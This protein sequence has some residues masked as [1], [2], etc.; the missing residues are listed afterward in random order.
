[1]SPYNDGLV[2]IYNDVA[3]IKHIKIEGFM[4]IDNKLQQLRQH[5]KQ[6][7]IAAYI[8]PSADFHQ[9]EMVGDYFQSRAYVS[10]FTGSQGTAVITKD[11]AC[12]WTD[13]RYFVQAELEL[14]DS[15][16]ELMKMR[17]P[18]YPTIHEFLINELTCGD[19]IGFDGRTVDM[20][21]GLAIQK[22]AHDKGGRV[23]TDID[24]IGLIWSDRPALSD[25]KVW[26][27]EEAYAGESSTSKLQRVRENMKESD[28][29][30]HL[31]T[32]LDDIAWLLNIRGADV[33]YNPFVLSYVCVWQDR[34]D[35]YID[36]S[37]LGEEVQAYLMNLGVK[38]Y[39]Y[40]SIYQRLQEIEDTNILLDESRVN[41]RIYSMIQDTDRIIRHMNPTILMK[42]KKNETEMKNTRLAHQ[43][44]GVA[45]TK[46]MYW[47]K[48][49]KDLGSVTERSAAAYME[50]LRS[51]QEGFLEQSFAPIVG[52]N[53][54]GAI[55]H[56][57]STK[58]TDVPLN[59]SGF[60]LVDTG[61]QYYEGTT[62][63][64]R[65]FAL[66]TITEEMKSHFTL[67]ATSMLSL[68]DAVFLSGCTGNN[69]DYRAREKFWKRGLD[70]KHGTGHGVGHL[71][72]VHEP[73]I[74]I[75]WQN[76]STYPAFEVGMVVSN[77]PG[78]YIEGK[79][80]I[81]LENLL[82]VQPAFET[83][84]GEFLKFETLTLA[85]IDLDAIAVDELSAEEK[86]LLNSYHK[87]VYDELAPYMDDKEL[88]W[89][90]EYTRVV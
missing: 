74:R 50:Q 56:Y 47:I 61:G 35:L 14:S 29:D 88:E 76:T 43:K 8:V 42:S 31:I 59:Q 36:S 54:H 81:R 87:R 21:E 38:L 82:L 86:Q 67:V 63:V 83:S 90:R 3:H 20:K 40:D 66:G 64:T 48:N 30:M 4:T 10:G 15:E 69:L 18:G 65:T 23:I 7:Q 68:S 55:V 53:E 19:N 32:T 5:M 72:G 49:H 75:A 85:P 78:L 80:G 51:E 52:L 22:I 71:G 44:D 70:Y 37:K 26:I 12:L 84:Y 25:K 9:S 28:A 60:L 34:V 17:E 73:P 2:N 24:L 41:F 89:L 39:P 57:S 45:L 1:M 33:L 6:E 13:G 11:R 62:D 58:E 16:F 77:E 46:F 27:F 79:Y